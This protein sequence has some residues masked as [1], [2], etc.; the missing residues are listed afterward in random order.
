MRFVLKFVLLL[1]LIPAAQASVTVSVNG[2]NHTIPQTNEK[3]WG[4]NVTAWIQAISSYTLQNSGGTFTL[5]SDV[6]TGATYGF[7][8]P[9]IKTA[10]ATPSTAGV[11][12]LAA[13][14]SIGWRNAANGANLLLA[15]DGTSVLTFNGSALSTAASGTFQDSTFNLYDNAD[16]TKKLAFEV[17][18]VST[19][20][21]RTI[22]MPDSNVNLGALVNANISGSAA[23]A[24]SKLN[25][26]TSILN[27]DLSASAAIDRAKLAT[28]SNYRLVTNG[29]AGAM[30]DASAITASRALISDVNGIPTHATTTS[31]EIGY[32][33][34]VTSAIQTQLDAKVLKSTYTAKGSILAAT[35]ASTPANVAVG[36]DGLFLKADSSNGN[37]V[38]WASPAGSGLAVTAKTTTYTATTSDDV[39][40][41]SSASPWTLTL[42]AASGN[43]GKVLRIKK[44]S[45][46][47]NAV[48]IDANAS[49]TIDGAL[50]TTI[51]TQYEELT[52]VCDGSNWHILER[53]ATT[54]WVTYVPALTGFGTPSGQ[55]FKSRRVGQNLEV[56]G[57]FV[58]G[59]A[60]ATPGLLAM[61]FN[62]TSGNVTIDT[63]AIPT[64]A[65][66]GAGAASGASATFF[67]VGWLAPA[68]NLTTV[69]LAGQT[70][71][72]NMSAAATNASSLVANGQAVHINVKVPIVGWN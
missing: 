10:T 19:A 49:E 17:S 9:Y 23:I 31:T 8:V 60:T 12:R 50:T 4:A 72:I 58:S 66:L 34:G 46:D 44:T 18:G 27:A 36:A 42:Y 67:G 64:S 35:A 32:V 63:A 37:G 59:I 56:V 40:T 20:T 6:D 68:S 62:G 47:L 33:N 24:Y 69:I 53:M 22:T 51:N 48:T 54:P 43:S 7:K 52:I 45:S 5:S 38:S 61:G 29:P 14:D 70:S 15:T 26:A 28:G 57:Y 1:A 13:T 55:A 41:V 3:G 16:A 25:L 11:L 2:V 71:T 65:F 21:T 30:A 39:I